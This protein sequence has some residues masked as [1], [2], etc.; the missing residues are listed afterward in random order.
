MCSGLCATLF[1][2]NI[3]A[4][5]AA[6]HIGENVTICGKMFGGKFLE[7]SEKQL[8]LLNLGAAYPNS[9]LTIKIEGVDRKKFEKNP[10]DYYLNKEICVTGTITE[11]KGKAEMQVTDTAQIKVAGAGE[12][13]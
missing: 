8:T 12:T 4:E 10:E 3:K 1:A 2:Q 5:E 9:P 7:R 13:N 11:F 6:K